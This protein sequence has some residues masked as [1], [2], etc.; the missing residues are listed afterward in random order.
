MSEQ[1]YKKQ[2][3]EQLWS[4]LSGADTCKSLLKK[5]LHKDGNDSRYNELKS[6]KTDLGGDL[7]DCI[8]SGKL[9]RVNRLF[10]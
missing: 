6:K 4:K 7:G 9:F 8:Q 3:L 5:H 2:P 1:E 10:N